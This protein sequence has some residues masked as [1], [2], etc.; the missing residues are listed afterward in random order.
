VEEG[1]LR[2]RLSA[3]VTEVDMPSRE[4]EDNF[5][6]MTSLE[7]SAVRTRTGGEDDAFILFHDQD[8]SIPA[9][10][11]RSRSVLGLS[12][13]SS[14]HDVFDNGYIIGPHNDGLS[15]IV[16]PSDP[17]QGIC[18]PGSLFYV[19]TGIEEYTIQVEPTLVDSN[20]TPP[21]EVRY[22]KYNVLSIGSEYDTI[23]SQ[24]VHELVGR[25]SRTNE[26]VSSNRG[27]LYINSCDIEHGGYPSINFR[28]GNDSSG[29]FVH[30]GTVVYEPQDY[31]KIMSN[32][33]CEIMLDFARQ[34]AYV[35]GYR[36]LTR[37]STHF[38]RNRI[39][40]CDPVST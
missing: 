40:F 36:F 12:P 10:P 20:Y 34:D 28:I 8:L 7:G 4:L 19:E 3:I 1:E 5:V 31:L 29:S 2:V 15:L 17:E 32:G 30:Q 24:I 25:I 6:I 38:G 14:I 33:Q 37:I 26:V 13:M 16:N 39:G 35:F 11:T 27:E 22:R 23:H 9:I 21:Q 18:E